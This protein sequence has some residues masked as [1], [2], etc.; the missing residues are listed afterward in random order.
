MW[1]LGECFGLFG[2]SVYVVNSWSWGCIGCVVVVRD[3]VGKWDVEGIWF[4]EFRRG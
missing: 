3:V 2:V 1:E 4:V